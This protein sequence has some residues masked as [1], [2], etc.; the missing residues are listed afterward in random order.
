MQITVILP[1]THN[2]ILYMYSSTWW[3]RIYGQFHSLFKKKSLHLCW[4]DWTPILN[5]PVTF[6]RAITQV[7][8]T[9]WKIFLHHWNCMLSNTK[10]PSLLLLIQT[11]IDFGYDWITFWNHIGFK[12]LMLMTYLDKAFIVNLLFFSLSKFLGE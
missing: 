4:R 5:C 7:L 3:F 6:R 11:H 10:E 8:R 12:S 2:H 1:N 9:Y